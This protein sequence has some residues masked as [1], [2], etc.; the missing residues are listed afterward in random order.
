FT[1]GNDR[2]QY[3]ETICGGAGAGPGFDGAD[4]VHTHMT[5]SRMTDVEVFEQNFPVIVESFS[6]RA[7]SGGNGKWHGG[8]GAIRR[9]RFLEPVAASI[10]SNHR[11]VAPFGLAGGG[12]ATTGVNRI[13]RANGTVE[14]L[15]GTATV[16]LDAGDAIVIE[17]PGGGG[18]GRP[19]LKL[20]PL[21][22]V[23]NQGCRSTR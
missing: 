18:F 1:F 6:I 9:L 22:P 2:V 14:E 21:N 16:E 23:V 20:E 8:S 5:N 15:D 12:S 4:A 19:D 11:R 17:T 7:G 3:Y 10:L 13:E